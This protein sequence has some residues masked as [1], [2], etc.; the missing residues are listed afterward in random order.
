LF[1]SFHIFLELLVVAIG[2]PPFGYKLT[3]QLLREFH[4]DVSTGLQAFFLA[5]A[6]NLLDSEHDLQDVQDRD[7][8]IWTIYKTF[9]SVYE[10]WHNLKG[11][12]P[13]SLSTR[14]LKKAKLLKLILLGTRPP[15]RLSLDM[16]PDHSA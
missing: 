10:S 3:F 2:V 8:G 15:R 7:T 9:P 5:A 12:Y 11:L 14:L 4:H 13:M 1:D 16:L 6:N